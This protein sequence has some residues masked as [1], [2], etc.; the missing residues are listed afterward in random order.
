MF[1][2]GILREYASPLSFTA[3]CMDIFF[4]LLGGGIAF[5]IKFG[6]IIL[7]TH[8]EVAFVLCVLLTL[9]FLPISGVYQ[10]WRGISWLHQAR[11]LTVAWIS[12]VIVLIIIAFATKT[13]AT[14][15]RQWIS[16]WAFFSWVFVLGYRMILYQILRTMRSKGWN[17]RRILIIGAGVLSRDVVKNIHNSAWMGLDIAGFLDDK[18]ELHGKY[19]DDIEVKGGIDQLALIVSREKIDEILITLPMQA[20][21][22]V[23]EIL[24]ML[25]HHTITV[26]YVPDIFGLRLINHSVTEF[27]GLPALNLT[28]SP[29]YGSNRVIKALEDKVLAFL[30]LLTIS[31]VLLLI[32]IGVK[33]SSQGPI[34][35]RQERVSWNGKP[36]V[37]YKFR[38]MPVDVETR[39]GPVWANGKEK[40]ATKFGAFL[41]R[42]SLDELPQFINVLKGDMSIVGPRPERPYFVEKFKEVVPDYMKKHLVKAGITGWAQINGWRGDTDLNKRIEYDLYYVENWS[43]WFDI[44][45]IVLTLFKGFVHK[46]AH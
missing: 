25:R 46:N 14:Y 18:K 5:Y 30:I 15:S 8:Y 29:M 45:I 32:T 7:P 24:Y 19:I 27:A 12:I 22:R 11:V 35:F 33:L 44:K 2:K 23:E 37:M 20:R 40:R 1:P 41:R 39:S 6:N 42:T 36:F 34:F 21:D 31:P 4:I 38:S 13:S 43:F 9:I 3:R 17:H 26:R 28:E 10:S 16:M